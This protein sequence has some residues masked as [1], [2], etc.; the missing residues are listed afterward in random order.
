VPK[1]ARR[2]KKHANQ[3]RNIN[4]SGTN[5]KGNSP[6]I[7]TDYSRPARILWASNA[8]FAGTGYGQQT[9]QVIKRFA[10]EG[11]EVAVSCNYGLEAAMSEWEGFTLYPRGMDVWSNDVTPANA[12]NWASADPTAPNLLITL[13]DC[14]IYKGDSWDKIPKVASWVPIDHMPL[15]HEVRNWLIRPNVEPIAM[16]KFGVRMLEHAGFRDVL[17]A[18]HGIESSE[19]QVRQSYVHANTTMTAKDLTQVD[20]DQFM[21]LMVAANKGQM[22]VRKAFP[23]AFLAF[24][25]FAKDRP[26]AV[27]FCYTEDKGAMGGINLRVLAEACNIAPNQ[28]QFINQYAYRQGLPQEALATIYS[29]ANVLL[30]PSMGEGFGIPAIEAQMCGTPII[31][32]DFSAQTELVGDGWLID[33]QP[34]WSAAQAA[35]L[36]SPNI[37][38]IVTA[39]NEAYERPRERSQKAMD[40]AAQYDADVVFDQYWKP[41]LERLL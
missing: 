25:K 3:H 21:V 9:A 26:D 13:F 34:H 40:F 19:F 35:W 24:S 16:S 27:L 2:N 37:A 20:D 6:A 4:S 8:P 36:H 28:I 7:P 11:H 15:P 32:S 31:A 30:M 18:P 12:I 1:S 14:W 38:S 41:A 10:K 23:E 33:G 5:Q 39:L 17:Y 22:P 29:R